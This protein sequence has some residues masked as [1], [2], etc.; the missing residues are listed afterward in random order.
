MQFIGTL[1]L[2]YKGW[3]AFA[4]WQPKQK[5]KLAL[6]LPPHQ[7]STASLLMWL[8]Q[9]FKY[10]PLNAALFTVSTSFLLML[11]K[12]FCTKIFSQN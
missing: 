3:I 2:H 6:P 4:C 9:G 8:Y 7:S 5:L 12:N 1:L 11:S 10:S